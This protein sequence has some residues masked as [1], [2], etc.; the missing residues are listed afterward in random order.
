M[1]RSLYWPP[2]LHVRELHR[3]W[4]EFCERF[5]APTHRVHGTWQEIE[6]AYQ[7]PERRYHTFEH[8]GEVLTLINI[9]LDGAPVPP[10]LTLAAWLHDLVYDTTR[11][12]SETESV[13]WAGELLPPLGFGDEVVVET[14]GMIA[15]TI[16]HQPPDDDHNAQVLC[17]AD[18]AILGSPPRRYE[19][20]AADVRWEYANVS[21]AAWREG[22]RHVLE[23]LLARPRLYHDVSMRGWETRARRNIG[24]ELAAVC[25][26]GV[27]T[28]RSPAARSRRTSTRPSTSTAPRETATTRRSSG[29]S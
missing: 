3:R 20:Y 21:E 28:R 15:M 27:R 14:C 26:E 25:A 17:D 18:L 22:R 29:T 8:V 2:P 19:R 4:V 16:S 24:S 10:A 11:T 5:G 13:R 9:I 1:S 7:A 12:D 6:G 23:S